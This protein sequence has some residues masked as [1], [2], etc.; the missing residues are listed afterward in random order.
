MHPAQSL[1]LIFDSLSNK[2]FSIWSLDQ[3]AGSIPILMP[4]V[5]VK[6]SINLG[7]WL[8]ISHDS[9]ACEKLNGQSDQLLKSNV[10]KTKA[11]YVHII[12][13]I[14]C[15]SKDV[16]NIYTAAEKN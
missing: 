8:C 12:Y 16:I 1:P 13:G 10:G 9:T 5:M 3:L 11:L 4:R 6:F 2:S 14:W 15:D 7:M